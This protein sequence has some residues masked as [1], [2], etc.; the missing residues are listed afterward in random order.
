[1]ENIKKYKKLIVIGLLLLIILLIIT[2]NKS[3]KKDDDN[4][5]TTNSINANII[6]E[7][8]TNEK[9][10]GNEVSENVS[11]ENVVNSTKDTTYKDKRSISSKIVYKKDATSVNNT[12]YNEKI[13]DITS[14]QL[15]I[16]YSTK[17]LTN[18]NIVVTMTSNE[19]LQNLEGWKLSA[20][21]LIL[22][23]EYTSNSNERLYIKDLEGNI[24]TINII[25]DN[26]DKNLPILDIT[27]S[28][29][30]FTNNDVMVKIKSNKQLNE[31][32]NW[33]LSPNKLELT[34]K[35]D[36]N[37]NENLI[38]KDIAGNE[39]N[40]N[41]VIDNIDKEKPEEAKIED[42]L[43]LTK[44]INTRL[45]L[46]DKQSGI[47]LNRTLYLIDS[48]ENMTEDYSKY[49]SID[50]ECINISK[51]VEN[52][53]IYYIHILSVDNSGNEMKNTIKLI[54]D[55]IET[56]LNVDYSTTSWTNDNVTV[57]VT[58]NKEMQQLDGW[59]LSEKVFSKEYT[60]NCNESVNFTDY[61]GRQ[62]TVTVSISN[63]DK[64]KPQEPVL[65]HTLFNTKSIDNTNNIDISFNTLIKDNDNGS[66]L[67]INKCK[68]LLNQSREKI[69][70]FN[71]AN[72]FNNQNQKL[73]FTLK[74]NSTYYLHI[75]LVDNVGNESYTI[76][77]IKN[78]TLNPIV[79]R[80]YNLKD[81]TNEN[82]VVTIKSN[83]TLQGKENWQVFD[84]GLT[85]RREYDKNISR[86]IETF[87]DL[88][89]NPVSV[90]ILISNIDKTAPNEATVNKT[91]FNT[92]KFNLVVHLSDNYS[93]I[94][95]DNS[96]YV[97]DSNN[98]SNYE[99]AKVFTNITETLNL[100][101]T[102]DGT[103]YLHILSVDQAG[104]E[105]DTI[106]EI[107]VDSAKPEAKVMYSRSDITNENVSIIIKTN[108]AIKPVLGWDL[109][110]D[111]KELRKTFNANINT[112][113]TIEDLFNNNN[114]IPLAINNIDKT[115]PKATIKY[116]TT[117]QTTDNVTVEIIANEIIRSTE[118]WTLSE[119]KLTLKKTFK[120][121][122]TETVTIKDLAGNSITLSVIVAN[123][124]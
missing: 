5:N 116:S 85:L 106:K 83:E 119:D 29:T 7:N 44:I 8:I 117:T 23:K 34:R 22:S 90:D 82:V 3:Q 46:E 64:Q 98:I 108:E 112:N 111:K 91:N 104:N 57:N 70:S 52:D 60:S 73:Y 87:Y 54:V 47:N 124:I 81:I 36:K 77:T 75:L 92:K 99:H 80:E 86:T 96:K 51:T 33:I 100:E 97:L 27:Y 16:N 67:N 12:N 42:R 72:T 69:N 25:I 28:D 20:D 88:A 48:N 17:E 114:I 107:N 118:G 76:H 26:I 68:Y 120:N 101:V 9:I 62:T 94:D 2:L 45:T 32:E 38:I 103:Y 31:F 18:K 14:P 50:A 102:T 21:K 79:T 115:F 30:E 56:T 24:T 40:I 61:A 4:Q 93:G 89:G 37:T 113:I 110:V 11:I 122:A 43:F 63:I 58:S 55:S 66:G 105:N 19:C 71:L 49:N 1:M 10:V 13:K 65:S 59:N 95:L 109:S 78:D 121:N 74:E 53:G 84:S 15:D 39:V 6:K 123:I 35:Y 41:I